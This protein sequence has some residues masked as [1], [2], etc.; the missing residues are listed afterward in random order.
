LPLEAAMVA[1]GGFPNVPR[2]MATA[3]E[4]WRLHGRDDGGEI[5]P[6]KGDV[7]KIVQQAEEHLTHLIA[8]FDQAATAYEARPN[9]DIAPKYSDYLHLARVKEWSA[10][11]G[12]DGS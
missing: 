1:K 11:S 2:K 8:T 9:P 10:V 12:E 4:F 3:L 6:V 7:A 5:V